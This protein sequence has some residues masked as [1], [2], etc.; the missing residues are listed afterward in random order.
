MWINK[1]DGSHPPIEHTLLSIRPTLTRYAP[2][3]GTDSVPVSKP[4]LICSPLPMLPL[5]LTCHLLW[6]ALP[7]RQ[8]RVRIQSCNSLCAL[9]LSLSI[10]HTSLKL[11]GYL[12]VSLT[13]LWTLGG[14][15][16]YPSYSPQD[17]TGI[18]LV[19]SKCLINN[20][21]WALFWALGTRRWIRYGNASS[22]RNPPE[23]GLE[24]VPLE[25]KALVLSVT[26]ISS[27][28]LEEPTPYLWDLGCNV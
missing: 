22:P 6:E 17:P 27:A 25:G 10:S 7:G 2:A 16:L 20:D 21:Y 23:V 5:S 12:L 28:K 3:V 26:I 18:W 24:W 1:L 11:C 15:G 9:L 13:E 8:I 4:G 14:Q 19:P